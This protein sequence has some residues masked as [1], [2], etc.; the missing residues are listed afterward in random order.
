ML[1]VRGESHPHDGDVLRRGEGEHFLPGAGAQEADFAV[2]DLQ[3]EQPAIRT[4]GGGAGELR[5]QGEDALPGAAVQ[6]A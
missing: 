5:G 3:R 2:I 6:M 1:A 4:E